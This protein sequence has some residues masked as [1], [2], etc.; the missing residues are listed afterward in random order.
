MAFNDFKLSVCT[1][2]GESQS[3]WNWRT[4]A[5]LSSSDLLDIPC[6]PLKTTS[7]IDRNL[8]AFTRSRFPQTV[9]ISFRRPLIW[10]KFIANAPFPNSI[11]LTFYT[12]AAQLSGGRRSPEA[13]YEF[14]RS[15]S[16]LHQITTLLPWPGLIVALF[17]ISHPSAVKLIF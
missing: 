2:S 1:S 8:D 12:S 13:L 5:I 11:I 6:I 16:L 14:T 15:T 17:S 4:L 3:H 10:Q 7:I 9:E